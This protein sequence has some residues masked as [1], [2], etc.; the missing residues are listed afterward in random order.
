MSH[1]PY[2]HAK[3]AD[4]DEFCPEEWPGHGPYP[5]AKNDECTDLCSEDGYSHAAEEARRRWEK[6]EYHRSQLRPK[7]G[8]PPVGVVPCDTC[9]GRGFHVVRTEP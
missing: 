1:G 2:P 3:M 4:C 5:H 8:G 6:K 9:D 7:A